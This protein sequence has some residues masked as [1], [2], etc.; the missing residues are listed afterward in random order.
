MKTPLCQVPELIKVFSFT[1]KDGTTIKGHGFNAYEAFTLKKPQDQWG[2]IVEWDYFPNETVPEAPH[3]PVIHADT[4]EV[5]EEE[6]F[7]LVFD[8]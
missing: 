7:E 6:T 5:E 2:N 1:M 3:I 4:S 8:R